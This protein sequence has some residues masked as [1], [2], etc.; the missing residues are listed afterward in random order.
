MTVYMV[1]VG[2][3]NLYLHPL[4]KQPGPRLAAS[5]RLWYCWH[6][7]RGTLIYAVHDAHKKYGD[8][9]RIAP[10]ELS[11][12]TAEAW[13]DIYG[14]RAGKEE[15]MKDPTFYSSISSGPGSIINAER[16]RHGHLRKKASHGFSEVALRSQEHF[17]TF[18][19]MGELVF[20]QSFECLDN[21]GYHPWVQLI[22]DSV[23]AGGFFRCSKYWPWLTPLVRQLI[24]SDIRQ[25]RVEQRLMAKEKADYRKSISDGR[26]DLISG[27]LKPD[28]GVM[29]HEYQSTVETL[30]IAG[31][32]TTATLMS[33][34][35]YYLVRDAK[36]M[37][38]LQDEVRKA[39]S[40]TK[41]INYDNVKKLPYLTACLDEALRIYPPVADT[42]PRNTGPRSEVI[43][44][45]LIPP[46]TT[47]GV[48]HW[49]TNH[50]PRN[51]TRPDDFIPERW[52]EGQTGFEN[53]KKDV[54]RPFHIGPRNCLGRNLAYFEMRL[55][56]AKLFWRFDFELDHRSLQWNE[57]KAFLLWEKPPMYIKL[58]LWPQ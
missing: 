52:L 32:E 15:M 7:V 11:C 37:A 49:S 29:P 12:I 54:T 34:V 36:R 39:F 40:S 41:E 55:L 26:Q 25:R 50:S 53:D 10:D 4:S 19:V 38:I 30:I 45:Q 51:Y 22:F 33:G 8:M 18:D 13:K 35:T 20:G 5:T 21:S 14:H 44:G 17:F 48:N 58:K 2:F 3:Y 6:C 28:S 42:F 56:I 24:P 27:F 1:A 23:K 9:V 31:S 47:I 43:N 16:S 57:Q 46:W